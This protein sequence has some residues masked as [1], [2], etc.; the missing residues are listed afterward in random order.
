MDQ[1][2]HFLLHNFVFTSSASSLYLASYLSLYHSL[3][4]SPLKICD[5][6]NEADERGRQTNEN[7]PGAGEKTNR[8]VK[9]SERPL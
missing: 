6:W 2:K 7:P 5:W 1:F 4:A 8:K 3:S 9:G